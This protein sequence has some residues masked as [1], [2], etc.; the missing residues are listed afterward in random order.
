MRYSLLDTPIY[1]IDRIGFTF[2]DEEPRDLVPIRS[3]FGLHLHKIQN[4]HDRNV[5]VL[6]DNNCRD[7]RSTNLT[8]RKTYAD[9]ISVWRKRICVRGATGRICQWN[10]RISTKGSRC[11]GIK[12]TKRRG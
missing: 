9:L 10:G 8:Q 5:D 4:T 7:D 11:P 2:I 6:I 12:T 3:E 1:E